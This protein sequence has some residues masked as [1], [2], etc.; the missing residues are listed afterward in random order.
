MSYVSSTCM[1][2]L[3]AN[4]DDKQ[5]GSAST[6]TYIEVDQVALDSDVDCKDI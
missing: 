3:H 4:D 6:Y 1:M 5:S 2:Y